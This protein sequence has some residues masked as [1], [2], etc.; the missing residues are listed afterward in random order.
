MKKI[1]SC[2]S[3]FFLSKPLLALEISPN[4]ES[5]QLDLL[6]VFYSSPIIYSVLLFLSFLAVIIWL[7]SIFTLKLSFLLPPR[8]LVDLRSL[9]LEKKYDAAL[10][11]CQNSHN[12]IA[13]IIASGICSR[14]HGHQVMLEAMQTEGKRCGVS[15]WQRISLLNDIAIIA[16]MLGL[17]GTVLGLFYAFYDVN[18]SPDT[19]VSIF[20]GLGI[21]VGT[22]VAG[23]IV[24]ILAM[25]F[26]ATLKLKVVR[27]L[28]SIEN[29]A[30][31][32]GHMINTEESRI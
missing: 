5:N 15:M 21:A 6:Q 28:N 31:A 10:S 25:I 22:T 16:P 18:R 14:M 19:L 7:Y 2:L 27:L 3:L 23:L 13:S 20:D 30:L 9:L 24:A 32:F 12:F 29:E 4:T 11:I 1:F 26:Y 17:L 8:F